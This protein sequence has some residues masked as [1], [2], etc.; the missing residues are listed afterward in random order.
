M[1]APDS[2]ETARIDARR[3]ASQV[4]MTSRSLTLPVI[5]ALIFLGGGALLIATT[6]WFIGAPA[7]SVNL[8]HVA[9][10]VE[11]ATDTKRHKEPIGTS[12]FALIV[13]DSD[14]KSVPLHVVKRHVKADDL[15]ALVGHRV[16]AL[17]HGGLVYE[18]RSDRG[19]PARCYSH[20]EERA[21]IKLDVNVSWSFAGGVISPSR[22]TTLDPNLLLRKR[23]LQRGIPARP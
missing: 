19:F 11:E 4:T 12:S 16:T 14:G 7:D 21:P 3:T 9:G 6:L 17:H 20:Y 2:A 15:R 5:V 13:R 1:P 8:R 22:K 18:L 23:T 10:V